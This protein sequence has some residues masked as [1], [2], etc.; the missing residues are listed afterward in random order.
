MSIEKIDR[1]FDANNYIK[2]FCYKNQIISYTNKINFTEK[3]IIYLNRKK[4]KTEIPINTS[5]YYYST[6]HN[7][8]EDTYKYLY[9]IITTVYIAC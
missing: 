9:Y 3:Y 4:I 1:L 6:Y 2:H 7:T 5:N 8:L